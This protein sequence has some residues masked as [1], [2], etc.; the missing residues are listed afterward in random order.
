VVFTQNNFLLRE[1]IVAACSFTR[2]PSVPDLSS[3]SFFYFH[4]SLPWCIP[5]RPSHIPYFLMWLY[6]TPTFALQKSVD[7][8]GWGWNDIKICNS[9]YCRTH[10]RTHAHTRS[11]S[12]GRGW[13]F[14][15]S[16]P[17]S[18]RLLVPVQPPIYWVPGALSQGAQR[19]GR[20]ADHSPPSSAG[21]KEWVELCLHSPNTTSWLG[22]QLRKHRDNFAF[23]FRFNFPYCR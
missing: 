5:P 13:E 8:V 7:L 22:A 3:L 19:P 11:S 20:E 17:H 23:T 10:A 6:E 16:P 15:S 21:V 2:R 12:P 18:D 1:E 14:F 4:F 9:S